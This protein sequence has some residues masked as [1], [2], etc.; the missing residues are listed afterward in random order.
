E[1][2]GIDDIH[3][4]DST[5]TIYEGASAD[6]QQAVNGGQKWIEFKQDNKLLAVVQPQGQN[7]GNVQLQTFMHTGT[8]RS[9]HG[10]YYLDRSFV[11][12]PATPLS[13]SVTMRIYFT[14]KESDSLLFAK[15]CSSCTFPK[16]PYRFGISYYKSV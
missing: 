14:D 2:V 9:F 1:G 3:I 16:N 12:K 15:S 13:D 4:Y 5:A 11:F 6:V 8:V 7:M 10:Q